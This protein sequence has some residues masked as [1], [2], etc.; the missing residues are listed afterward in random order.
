[1]SKCNEN[2]KDL[3]KMTRFMTKMVDLRDILRQET[4]CKT[5]SFSSSYFVVRK[6]FKVRIK[7]YNMEN[8]IV[9]VDLRHH[10]YRQGQNIPKKCFSEQFIPHSFGVRRDSS[11]LYIPTVKEDLLE[12]NI[13]YLNFTFYRNILPATVSNVRQ[14]GNLSYTQRVYVSTLRLS[15]VHFVIKD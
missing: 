2:S 6:F 4:I 1:M 15:T 14:R 11:K 3:V 9:S 8:L 5:S 13:V 7:F 12:I 10:V